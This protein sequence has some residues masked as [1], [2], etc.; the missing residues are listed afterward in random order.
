MS[1][2]IKRLLY[3]LTVAFGTGT[4]VGTLVLL[5][6]Q[7]IWNKKRER[8]MKHDKEITVLFEQRGWTVIRVWE[9]ELKKKNRIDLL[10]KLLECL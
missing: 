5:I 7:S 3:L 9:C 8:N 6:M 2:L 1:F 4:I 10:N